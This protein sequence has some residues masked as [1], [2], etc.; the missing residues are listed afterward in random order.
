MLCYRALA[1]LLSECNLARLQWA[2]NDPVPFSFPFP[3]ITPR[4]LG[5]LVAHSKITKRPRPRS[6]LGPRPR[7]YALADVRFLLRGDHPLPPLKG[8]SCRPDASRLCFVLLRDA[9]S[10]AR[11]VP[12]VSKGPEP[13]ISR[14][15]AR[16]KTLICVGITLP[17]KM[18][19]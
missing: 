19:K 13:H 3:S 2:P 11:I 12:E 15:P 7:F 8:R 4:A 1:E 5:F 16:F 9:P 17:R 6:K 10:A 18:A 14:T